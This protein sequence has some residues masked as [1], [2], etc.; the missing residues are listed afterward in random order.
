MITRLVDYLKAQ[1]NVT[2]QWGVNDC[3][4]FASAGVLATTGF[5]PMQQW[6][7]KYTT[8]TG[9][10][11][12]LKKHGGGSVK[13]AFTHVF[14]ELKPRLNARCG[15]LALVDT[16]LGDAVG[17]VHACRVWVMSPTGLTNLPISQAKGIWQVNKECK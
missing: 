9:A 16:E 11:R 8:E 12:L 7:G 4:L 17:I 10:M 1:Q 15:D 6:R 13:A 3:C 5:D 14:G 2:F